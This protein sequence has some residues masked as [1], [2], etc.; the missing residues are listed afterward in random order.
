MLKEGAEDVEVSTKK[1]GKNRKTEDE[2]KHLTTMNVVLSSPYVALQNGYRVEAVR[3]LKANG[4]NAQISWNSELGMWVFCSKNVALLA[5][6]EDDLE[7]YCGDTRSRYAFAYLISK[8]WFNKLNEMEASKIEE[9]KADI[10]GKTM[11]G[12]YCGDPNHMHLIIYP[13]VRIIFYTIVDNNSEYSCLLPEES[14][15][16][17]KKYSLEC[18][19]FESLGVFDSYQDLKLCLKKTYRSVACDTITKAEEGSVIYLIRRSLNVESQGEDRILSLA[20]MKTLEYRMYRKLRE[21]IKTVY[22]RLRSKKKSEVSE[23]QSWTTMVNKFKTEAKELTIDPDSQ[24]MMISQTEMDYYLNI[25]QA[26]ADKC[27]DD[28]HE[29]D[30]AINSYL[31]FLK[32]IIEGTT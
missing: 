16:I 4:E 19:T 13:K 18:V 8:A 15:R 32:G 11:V 17:F 5:R 24:E 20:K 26:V 6:E 29:Q 2:M 31:T 28:T 22:Y 21:K 10:D 12:E 1:D 3:T 25:A 30:S 14:C 7:K 9:L 23:K 27:Y